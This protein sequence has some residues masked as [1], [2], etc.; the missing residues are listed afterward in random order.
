MERLHYR[1][2]AYATLQSHDFGE[3][4]LE[5][6]FGSMDFTVATSGAVHSDSA[7]S[8]NLDAV[9]VAQFSVTV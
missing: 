4:S 3:V 8:S 1:R 2:C 5:L 9:F 6:T 7:S